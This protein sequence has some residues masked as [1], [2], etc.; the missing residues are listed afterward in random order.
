MD[1]SWED[2]LPSSVND[3]NE[4]TMPD[5]TNPAMN[6]HIPSLY[7]L[8]HLFGPVSEPTGPYKA[9]EMDVGA[10]SSDDDLEWEEIDIMKEGIEKGLPSQSVEVI[11]EDVPKDS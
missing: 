2:S 4:D 6:G 3:E 7:P 9:T 1:V 5:L 11:I 8:P 10:S